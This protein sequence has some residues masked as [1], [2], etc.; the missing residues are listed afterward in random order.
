MSRQQLSI[1]VD[2]TQHI[3]SMAQILLKGLFKMMPSK[4]P[5]FHMKTIE[6]QTT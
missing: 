6:N 4:Q 3:L 1:F 5:K 2:I